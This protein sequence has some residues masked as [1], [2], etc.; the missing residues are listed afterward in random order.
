M[1]RTL[2]STVAALAIAAAVAI[3]VVAQPQRSGQRGGGPGFGGRGG[4]FPALRGLNLNDAQRE[5]IR[6]IAQQQRTDDNSPQRKVADLNKQLHL[7]ILADAPDLQKI[8][9]LKTSIAAATAEAL[10]A[11][12]DVQTRIAQ[13]LTPEQRAQA[14]EALTKAGPRRP[15]NGRRGI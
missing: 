13:V 12:V 4:P 9:E 7:A 14:R 5:Q 11:Q 15:P 6:S 10:T 1:K 8:D 3:P 2:W